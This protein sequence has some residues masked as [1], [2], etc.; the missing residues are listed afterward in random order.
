MKE[1]MK[2][3]LYNTNDPKWLEES[4]KE[5]WTEGDLPKGELYARNLEQWALM[6]KR[7]KE[8][9]IQKPVARE[10]EKYS[11]NKRKTKNNPEKKR[12]KTKNTNTKK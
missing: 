4:V 11:R 5:N 3:L 7:L 2:M 10:R 8:F 9:C 12:T 1:I 6:H